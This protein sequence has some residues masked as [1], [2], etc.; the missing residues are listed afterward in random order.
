MIY[1]TVDNKQLRSALDRRHQNVNLSRRRH[2]FVAG[3][4]V[5]A[6]DITTASFI[7]ITI[8]VELDPSTNIDVS[9]FSGRSERDIASY[10]SVIALSIK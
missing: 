4:D 9:L 10:I 8:C 6:A 1:K 3:A 7:T 5:G 2:L